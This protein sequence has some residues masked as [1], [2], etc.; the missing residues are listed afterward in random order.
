MKAAAVLLPLNRDQY[1]FQFQAVRIVILNHWSDISWHVLKKL[2]SDRGCLLVIVRITLYSALY[3][4]QIG[5]NRVPIIACTTTASPECHNMISLFYSVFL[6]LSFFDSFSVVSRYTLGA[7][8]ST[9]IT[10]PISILSYSLS[11][12]PYLQEG[13][14]LWREIFNSFRSLSHLI[15][16]SRE[17]KKA[18]FGLALWQSLSSIYP[19][20]SPNTDNPALHNNKI[21][22]LLLL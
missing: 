15:H 18:S 1:M 5:F 13:W 14:S 22:L 2:Q 17:E 8:H 12:L 3:V 19:P 10:K 4:Q 6:F 16:S 20:K 11:S 9:T 7:H 21:I